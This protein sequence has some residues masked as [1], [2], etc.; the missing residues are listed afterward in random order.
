MSPI[1][2]SI[3]LAESQV[4]QWS[5]E[6]LTMERRVSSNVDRALNAAAGSYRRRIFM[7]VAE[8]TVRRVLDCR[9]KRDQARA[10]LNQLLA[11]S[12]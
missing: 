4:R 9:A 1:T 2:S 12:L 3:L 7:A 6:A 5:R 8:V 11:G 10:R